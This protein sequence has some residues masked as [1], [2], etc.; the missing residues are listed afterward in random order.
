MKRKTIQFVL[1]TLVLSFADVAHSDTFTTGLHGEQVTTE[2]KLVTLDGQT[3]FDTK[4]GG[5]FLGARDLAP[6][7]SPELLKQAKEAQ[8]AETKGVA[9]TVQGHPISGF[10]AVAG[11]EGMHVWVDLSTGDMNFGN[12]MRYDVLQLKREVLFKE[13]EIKLLRR[14]KGK[15]IGID[16]YV[17]SKGAKIA[18][19]KQKSKLY[20]TGITH[21]FVPTDASDKT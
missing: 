10:K 18:P 6:I 21:T 20:I 14:E 3:Y 12:G 13:G 16:V 4:T 19:A 2:M 8:I 17:C 7:L 15:G 11:S 1:V 9:A 5:A